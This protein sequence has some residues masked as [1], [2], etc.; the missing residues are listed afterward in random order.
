ML[1]GLEKI[2]FVLCKLCMNNNYVYN[3]VCGSIQMQSIPEEMH[4]ENVAY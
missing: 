1:N 2:V 3:I 4:V